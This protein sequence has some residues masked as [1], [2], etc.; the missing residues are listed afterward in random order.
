MW[1]E[2][3]R[4]DGLKSFLNY[5]GTLA[6]IVDTPDNAVMQKDMR[7]AVIELS[8]HCTVGIISGRDLKDIQQMVQIDSIVHAGK[9]R[10]QGRGMRWVIVMQESIRL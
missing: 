4:I 1:M 9:S 7:T 6:P 3:H 8:R 5:D 2:N 10:I